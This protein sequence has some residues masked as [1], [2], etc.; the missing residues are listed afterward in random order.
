MD[1]LQLGVG[2]DVVVDGYLLSLWYYG[3]SVMY[4]VNGR[5]WGRARFDSPPQRVRRAQP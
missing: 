1:G 2:P 5:V 3:R 4:V